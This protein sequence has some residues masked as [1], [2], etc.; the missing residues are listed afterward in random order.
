MESLRLGRGRELRL[1]GGHLWVYATDVQRV[2]GAPGP[3][4]PVLVRARDGRV[5]GTGLFN[6]SG[7]IVARL[8]TRGEAR[9]SEELVA[10]RIRDAA[11]ARQG[12]DLV[13]DMYRVV[14]GES[15]GLPGLVVDRYGEHLVIQLLSMGMEV[16]RD[17]IVTS[18]VELL[19]PRSITEVRSSVHRRREGL[20]RGEPTVIHGEAP[21]D[22]LV[23]EERGIRYLVDVGTGPKGGFFTD[24]RENRVALGRYVRPGDEVLDLFA[25]SGGFGFAAAKAGAGRV[26]L[27]D[28]AK[29]TLERA[30]E[31]ADLNQVEVGL[32]RVDLFSEI[33]DLAKEL[34]P[35]HDVVVL[36]PPGIAKHAKALPAATR[37]YL[38]LNQAALSMVR[39]G[40]LLVSCSCSQPMSTVGLLGVVG[41]AAVRS[42]RRVSVLEIRGSG[43]D[44]PIL[45]GMPETKYLDAIFVR[46][47]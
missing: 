42:G 36:D 43:P 2:E 37:A 5:L 27:V 20:D 7:K 40:G 21:E 35:V 39:Q 34:G 32:L 24:Q 14:H 1:L 26:T 47:L 17:A 31:S 44:H 46:V 33:R 19:S 8:V 18:L 6:P 38:K 41:Q 28:S 4:E 22:A 13:T 15:D 29:A 10:Q 45:P 25:G 9:W 12:L 3:G 30:R 11:E 16:R 23:L